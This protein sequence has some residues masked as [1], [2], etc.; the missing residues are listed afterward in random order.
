MTGRSLQTNKDKI[1]KYLVEVLYGF[2]GEHN[3][4]CFLD[5]LMVG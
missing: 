5:R 3:K 4:I 2:G 1:M